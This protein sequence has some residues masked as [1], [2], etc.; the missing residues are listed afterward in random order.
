MKFHHLDPSTFTQPSWFYLNSFLAGGGGGGLCPPG[1]L[2]LHTAF[3]VL[4]KFIFGP[5]G[6]GGGFAHLDPSTF[7]QPS[8]FYLN[9]FLPGGGGG[10]G[11]L[12]PPGSLCLHSAWYLRPLEHRLKFPDYR[13]SS[14]PM[15]VWLFFCVLCVRYMCVP[16]NFLCFVCKIYKCVY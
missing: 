5:R 12:C 7:T 4:L 10:G 8:W 1:P 16:I 13:N 2:Y 15:Q 9:S 11:G 14:I 3:L 6:G